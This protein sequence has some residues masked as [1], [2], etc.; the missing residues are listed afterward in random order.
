MSMI[1]F[2]NSQTWIDFGVKNLIFQ[3]LMAKKGARNMHFPDVQKI[4]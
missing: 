2:L 1:L 4:T 3:N